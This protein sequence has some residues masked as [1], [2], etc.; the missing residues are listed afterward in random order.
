[1]L[2][3]THVYVI[4]LR[5]PQI[6]GQYDHLQHQI[7]QAKGDEMNYEHEHASGSTSPSEPSVT[8]LCTKHRSTASQCPSCST[9][10]AIPFTRYIL[11]IQYF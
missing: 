10:Y 7:L 3:P 1:V 6:P 4:T 8:V 2:L 9:V 11:L 5:D